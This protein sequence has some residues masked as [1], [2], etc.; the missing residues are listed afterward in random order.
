[1]VHYYTVLVLR[2]PHTNLLLLMNF[3]C[4]KKSHKFGLYCMSKNAKFAVGLNSSSHFVPVVRYVARA[5][6]EISNLAKG[7]APQIVKEPLD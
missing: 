5:L 6:H 3:N 2:F 7:S 1:M 4:I